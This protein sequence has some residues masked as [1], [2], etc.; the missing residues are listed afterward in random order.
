MIHAVVLVV[1]ALVVLP[2]LFYTALV[3]GWL[4]LIVVEA[5]FLEPFHDMR[6]RRRKR[7]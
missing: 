7:Q 3:A 5:L 6:E 4:V 2:M 1:S